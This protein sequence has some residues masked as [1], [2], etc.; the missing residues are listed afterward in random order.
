MRK[1]ATP[2]ATSVTKSNGTKMAADDPTK[3]GDINLTLGDNNKLGNVGHTVIQ[4]APPSVQ[5]VGRTATDMPDG[6]LAI[7]FRVSLSK[8]ASRIVFQAHGANLRS[9]RIMRPP[10]GGVASVT[11]SDM[12][13]SEGPGLLT[14]EFGHASGEYDVCVVTS[15][16]EEARLAWKIEP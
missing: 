12:I 16:K 3:I 15:N 4:E 8:P 5:I 10:R 6:G 2:L 7:V 14:E 9:L 13:R 11:K 1:T